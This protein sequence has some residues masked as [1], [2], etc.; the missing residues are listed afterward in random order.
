L[1]TLTSQ[2][3]R[4]DSSACLSNKL[5]NWDF[6]TT[7]DIEEAVKFFTD[8]VQ[9]AGWKATTP[10]PARHKINDCPLIIQQQLAVKRKLRRDWHRFRTPD[11]NRPLN[12]ATQDLKQLIRT[13]KN[14]Q[15]QTFHQ[16]LSPTAA[17]DYSLW[18]ATKHLKL[19]TLPSPPLRTHLGTWANSNFDKEQ[20]LLI[21]YRKFFNHTLQK[22][23]QQMMK[24]SC[25][26]S[27]PSIN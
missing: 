19:V 15:V 5:T 24:L 14:E 8:S 10:F 25:N 27:K 12:A 23:Y 4:P 1:V 6:K 9:W 20:D 17:T 21:T 7:D 13:I 3:I 18:K 2:P 26:F 11:T 22:I 16:E